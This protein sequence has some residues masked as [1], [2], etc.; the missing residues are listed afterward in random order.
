MNRTNSESILT[1]NSSRLGWVDAARAIAM[2]FVY[3]GHW[4]TAR[5]E[6]TAYSFHLQLFFMISGFFALNNQRKNTKE[7]LIKQFFSLI[8][9]MFLWSFIS[10]VYLRLDA[11]SFQ[12]SEILGWLSNPGAVQPNYWF[13]PAIAGVVI[14]AYF[15][16]KLVKKPWIMLLI[17]VFLNFIWGE[18]GVVEA[19]KNIFRIFS[20]LP[21]I[22]VITSW[23][24][25]GA[26]TTYL[27]WYSIGACS[28]N[29][30]KKI[31]TIIDDKGSSKSNIIHFT[32]IFTVVVTGILILC[33]YNIDPIMGIV[34]SNM[35]IFNIYKII[36]TL[37]TSCAVLYLSYFLQRSKILTTIGRNSMSMFGLE[38]IT[39][40]YIPLSLL[41]MINLGVPN[42]KGSV[43]VITI[44]VFHI[45]INY[46]IAK[47]IENYFPALNGRAVLLSVGRKPLPDEKKDKASEI[48]TKSEV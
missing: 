41:P 5:I 31:F 15:I 13:F 37:I 22:K 40:S 45:M 36:L 20:D 9:P 8:V 33:Q 18:N 14:S 32:G 26:S 4:L 47:A 39:H 16:L 46:V 17:A 44:E 38:Y 11:E 43:D 1:Q 3:L 7:F 29:F 12:F 28:F 23:V 19:E 6:V 34:Y 30:L 21:V 35:I 10:F 25:F 24:S 27:L 42:I 2:I 48:K